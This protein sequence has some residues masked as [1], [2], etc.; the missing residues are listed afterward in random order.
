MFHKT[1]KEEKT[2]LR[3]RDPFIFTDTKRKLYFLFGTGAA[4]DGAANIDPYFEV[5]VGEKSG[6]SLPAHTFVL[7]LPQDFGASSITG[8]GN[9]R[10]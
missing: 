4:C 3:M 9:S 8:R 1:G 6:S 5:Y 2:D 7:N 10:I